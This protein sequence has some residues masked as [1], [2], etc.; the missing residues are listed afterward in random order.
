MTRLTCFVVLS[1]VT[2][3]YSLATPHPV[4]QV[5]KTA[6]TLRGGAT[7]NLAGLGA[8]YASALS[9]SPIV[10]KSVTS[11]AIFALSDVAG[12]TIEGS[13]GG[14]DVQRTLTSGLVGLLY[15]G[16]ALHYWLIMITHFFP[17]FDVKSTLLKTLMGQAIFGPTITCVFFGAALISASGLLG[18]LS[19]LPAKIK[20]DL[21]KTW[22]AGLGFWPLVDLVCY[23]LVQPFLGASWIPLSYNIASFFWTIFLSLQAARDVA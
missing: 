7:M 22:S 8:A 2:P 19:Q 4:R 18:G 5:R 20:Q 3:L 13:K 6:L 11:G 1:L 9:A 10:T 17:G 16:P 15:F 14:A 21:F 23:G 12:Q